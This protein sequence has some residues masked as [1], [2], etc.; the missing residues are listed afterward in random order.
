[1]GATG[2]D[3]TTGFTLMHEGGG[4]SVCACS[5]RART[6]CELT[7]SGELGHVRMNTQ[8]HRTKSVSV[9]LADGAARTVQTPFIGN[10]YAHEAIEAQRCF[11]AGEIESPGMTHD[12]TLALMGVMDTIREQIGLRYAADLA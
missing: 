3:V 8:F 9:A 12:E 7:V 4:M 6:P 5:L 10:G 1:M 11:L 2:V